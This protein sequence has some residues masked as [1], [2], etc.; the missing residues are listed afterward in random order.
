MTCLAPP[1]VG[2]KQYNT[3]NHQPSRHKPQAAQHRLD[4]VLQE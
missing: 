3:P 4:R 2:Q 1:A